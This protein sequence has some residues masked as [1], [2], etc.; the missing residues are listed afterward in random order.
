MKPKTPPGAESEILKIGNERKTA[1]CC[2]RVVDPLKDCQAVEAGAAE[3]GFSHYSRIFKKDLAAKPGFFKKSC[4]GEPGIRKIGSFFELSFPKI[5]PSGKFDSLKVSRFGKFLFSKRGGAWKI[6]F[7]KI[8]IA[9]GQFA[10]QG[11]VKGIS[12][13]FRGQGMKDAQSFRIFLPHRVLAIVP[14]PGILYPTFAAGHM[15]TSET[16]KIPGAAW[17]TQ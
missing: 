12:I 14:F 8:E 3:I 2:P 1:G 5:G 9:T 6:Y 11:L 10:L 16:T 13:F 15:R 4:L 7:T 17:G